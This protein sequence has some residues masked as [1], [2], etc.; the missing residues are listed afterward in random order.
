MQNYMEIAYKQAKKAF[1]NKEVPVG[2]VIVKNNKIIA[3]SR[4]NRQKKYNLLGH[5]EI[6]CIL[7][8]EKKLKDWRLDGCD[9]YVTLQPCDMCAMV[10][11]ES[12]LNRV[13]FLISQEKCIKNSNFLQTNDCDELTNSYKNILNNFFSDLRK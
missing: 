8:A 11:K 2:A 13:F 4:N 6:N 12:R 9:M 5:A 1:N 3:V 10:I 7:K